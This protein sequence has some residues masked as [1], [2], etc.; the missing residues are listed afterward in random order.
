MP[1]ASA[2]VLCQL[3]MLLMLQ[4]QCAR[5]GARRISVQDLDCQ[6]P[7]PA[8]LNLRAPESVCGRWV[9]AVETAPLDSEPELG[10]PG[11]ES[12]HIDHG[13]RMRGCHWEAQAGDRTRTR[14]KRRAGRGGLDDSERDVCTR[15]SAAH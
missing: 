6:C 9:S 8:A 1:D 11:D 5:S 2:S 13:I 14:G 3:L 7:P 10:P 15:V 4:I 12:M